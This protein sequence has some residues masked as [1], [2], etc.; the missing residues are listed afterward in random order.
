LTTPIIAIVS[1]SGVCI[2]AIFIPS[3]LFFSPTSR[4]VASSVKHQTI[5]VTAS[6]SLLRTGMGPETRFCTKC[7]RKKPL[8]ASA[9]V[10]RRYGYSKVCKPCLDKVSQQAS[11]KHGARSGDKENLPL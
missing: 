11:E 5:D 1:E 3:I 10:Q 7:K 4:R 9:F 6:A 8:N 2:V